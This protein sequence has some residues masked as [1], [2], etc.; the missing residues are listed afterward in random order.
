MT[1]KIVLRQIMTN[2]RQPLL[3]KESSSLTTTGRSLRR[4]L[5]PS[6]S[7]PTTPGGSKRFAEVAGRATA[8]CAAICC[9]CPCGIMNLLVLAV[10][11]LPAGLCRKALKHK[12]I[13]RLK[14]NGIF[15]QQQ[16]KRRCHCGCD[17]TDIQIHPLS[18][19]HKGDVTSEWGDE[20][21]KLTSDLISNQT[22]T[23]M[24]SAGKE[25]Q[26]LEVEMWDKF[27][28]TGFWRSPSQRDDLNDLPIITLD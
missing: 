1:R 24:L 10:Y 3:T 26:D 27:Y 2:K 23:V 20:D 4:N 5:Q 7:S 19:V 22:G 6:S 12:K 28:G 18:V 17:D 13:K 25:I 15:Q 16:H 21:N 9:C 11:K 8:E 14:K